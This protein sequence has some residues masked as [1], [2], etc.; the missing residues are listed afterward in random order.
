MENIE[1]KKPWQELKALAEA[2]NAEQL[3]QYLHE[4]PPG[5]PEWAL[6]RLP[7]EE[8]AEVVG[9]LPEKDAAALLAEIPEV[10][11][12]EIVEHLP[13]EQAAAI[14]SE[15]PSNRQA[16][17]LGSLRVDQ[18]EEILSHLPPDDASE[19]RHLMEFAPGTAG[20][21][22]AT[23][24]LAFGEE[25]TIEDVL[26]NMRENADTYESYDV[27][28]AYVQSKSGKLVGVLRVRD[29]L[30]SR[31][32]CQVSSI[33][34]KEPVSVRH[35]LGLTDLR[36][37]FDRYP[38]IALPVTDDA[39]HMAGVVRQT[40]VEEATEQE[41]SR[42][43]LKFAGILGGEEIRSLPLRAR[44]ARR[45]AWLSINI[46]LNL[47]AASVIAYYQDTLAAV[48]SLAV[49]LPIISDMSGC[50]GSQAVAVSIREL[51]LGLLKPYEVLRVLWKEASVGVV[52]GIALGIL[53]GAAAFIWKGTPMLGV[54]VGGA[55]ALNTII[56][57]CLGGAI[58]LILRWA[59]Q[60]PALASGPILTTV[61]D[62][63]GFFLVLSF[64]NAALPWLI[65]S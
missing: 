57:V 49:F 51:G 43:F 44:S 31:R 19:V 65:T 23:E 3:E 60:D 4:L 22:M 11:A 25:D 2:G 46:V 35:D 63:C 21:L 56:A 52:N 58:P 37:T 42:S 9:L 32:T 6:S 5:D 47:I 55:L 13:S 36:L 24:Y 10:Q 54:V 18:T 39:G 45:L 26:N 8:Q 14:V 34:L 59:K 33:M 30:F 53:L 27:Q 62:M 28:Y 48:I 38:L 1:Q 29:L 41:A 20:G 40:D 17:L 7:D 64:A 12:V 15:A 16:Q 61:T 50:S